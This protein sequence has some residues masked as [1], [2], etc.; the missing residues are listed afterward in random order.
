MPILGTI[1]FCLMLNQVLAIATIVDLL[2]Q[3]AIGIVKKQVVR[4]Q[5]LLHAVSIFAITMWPQ[6]E[7]YACPSDGHGINAI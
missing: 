1:W 3:T 4:R 2:F 7:S 5:Q 6:M